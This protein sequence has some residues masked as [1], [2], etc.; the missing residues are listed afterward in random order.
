MGASAARVET[1]DPMQHAEPIN[2]PGQ[3]NNLSDGGGVL[4]FF[5]A[6]R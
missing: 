3:L 6:Y 1:E 2:F 4:V 5:V